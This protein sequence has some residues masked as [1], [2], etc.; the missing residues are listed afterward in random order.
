MQPGKIIKLFILLVMPMLIL[1]E[2]CGV[3]SGENK[4]KI[5][6]EAMSTGGDSR[7]KDSKTAKPEN[8]RWETTIQSFEEWDSKNS[9]PPDAVLFVGSS[10]IRLWATR[11]YFTEFPVINRGFGGCHISDVN[12]FARRIV[13]PYKPKVIVFYAGDND[14]A[15]RKTPQRVFD[16]YRKFVN[17]VHKE[18]AATR[19]IFVGIKPSLS[20]WSLWP[21]MKEANLMIKEF[22][23][24][25]KRLFIF[26]SSAPLLGSNGKPNERLFLKDNLHLNSKGYDAWTRMLKPVIKK[27][28]KPESKALVTASE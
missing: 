4:P 6:H 22:S 9:F 18:L 15:G 11:D 21:L 16:D 10:S 13:L 12:Y 24:K 23:D 26:D 19:I 20:R 5:R 7:S 17:L 2:S 1:S 14:I 27:A 25:D 3:S 8:N 28:L